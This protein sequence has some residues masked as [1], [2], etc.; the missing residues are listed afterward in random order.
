ME[1][2]NQIKHGIIHSIHKGIARFW[3]H[4]IET[5][6]EPTLY[7]EN[8]LGY[9]KLIID[10]FTWF[11][12]LGRV[13]VLDLRVSVMQ[14]VGN[15]WNIIYIGNG[16]SVEAIS[17]IF[18]LQPPKVIEMNRASLW[19]IQK[20]INNL[21]QNNDIVVC[22]FNKI[23]KLSQ[24]NNN[25][26]FTTPVWIK[27]KINHID[28][29]IDEILAD[30]NQ[31][32]RRRIR[33]L[34]KQGFSYSYTQERNDFDRF[35]HNMYLPYI[36]SRYYGKGIVLQDYESLNKVFQRGGLLLVKQGQDEVCG[37]LY[38][39][40]K[41]TC[42]AW[43]MGVLNGD[44]NLVKKGSLIALWWF[45][46]DWARRQKARR[47]DLGASRAL[48]SNGPFNFKRQWGSKVYP[49]R[50]VF[51][52]WTFICQG[53]SSNMRQFL[54]EK[55]LIT[56]TGDKDYQLYFIDPDA[57]LENIDFSQLLY[58]TASSGLNGIFALNGNNFNRIIPV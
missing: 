15:E 57:D 43:Q 6:I 11:A 35:F 23:I 37:M 46:L 44:F 1:I 20:L 38:D 16:A 8:L 41:D 18:F 4:P 33:Q 55:G 31:T 45:M 21:I 30:M 17:S 49:D 2:M 22:E 14:L 56:E 40:I 52:Q 13:F 25:L 53:L 7:S 32:M 50:G 42:R 47:F 3:I 12:N 48:T 26:L 34:E 29:P 36:Q 28:R 24:F 39:I 19:Q 51:S 58:Q 27:Q 5:L 9:K 10:F 54:N